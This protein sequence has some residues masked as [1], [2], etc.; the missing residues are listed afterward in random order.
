MMNYRKNKC[1]MLMSQNGMNDRDFRP[2]A[3]LG[4]TFLFIRI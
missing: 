4:V 3:L 2:L 1:N